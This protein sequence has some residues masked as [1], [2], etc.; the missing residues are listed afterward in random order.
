MQKY[1]HIM[2][3]RNE[4]GSPPV[5]H[6]V[7]CGPIISGVLLG[8]PKQVWYNVMQ[9]FGRG[10]PL[11]SREPGARTRTLELSSFLYGHSPPCKFRTKGC[12]QGHHRA[13]LNFETPFSGTS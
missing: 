11:L 9:F 3:I 7:L 1:L 4:G 12:F 13:S 10:I 5:D 6:S 2:T 8:W